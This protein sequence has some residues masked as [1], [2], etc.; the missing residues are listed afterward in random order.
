MSLLKVQKY[1]MLHKNAFNGKFMLLV[2]IKYIQV[3]T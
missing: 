2:T 1:Y 3:F